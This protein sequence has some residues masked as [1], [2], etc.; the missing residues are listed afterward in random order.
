MWGNNLRISSMET[1]F[2]TSK[3]SCMMQVQKNAVIMQFVAP[4]GES[5]C[6]DRSATMVA[7]SHKSSRRFGRHNLSEAQKKQCLVQP[8]LGFTHSEEGHVYA[9]QSSRVCRVSPNIQ[10][11]QALQFKS[12]SLELD[13]A[14]RVPK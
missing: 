7:T 12:V 8:S 3:V 11:C 14:M 9:M 13:G 4:V 5:P 1:C 2:I 10:D 6:R